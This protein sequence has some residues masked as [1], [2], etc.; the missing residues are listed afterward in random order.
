MNASTPALTAFRRAFQS[1]P[2]ARSLPALF[3]LGPEM[4]SAAEVVASWRPA[5][6]FQLPEAP[7]GS[8]ALREA[9][10]RAVEQLPLG[11]IVMCAE[12]SVPPDRAPERREQLLEICA[13]FRGDRRLGPML[14]TGGLLLSALWFDT[15]E[16]DLFLWDEERHGFSLLD[17]PGLERWFLEI[18]GRATRSRTEAV[19]GR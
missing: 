1:P 9:M 19:G 14:R 6:S 15:L 16:G 13:A 10:V 7:R 5:V 4:A 18:R 2:A 3:V 12:C 17:D 11:A 8:T